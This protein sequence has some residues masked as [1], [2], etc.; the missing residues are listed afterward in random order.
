MD[1]DALPYI[2]RRVPHW[3]ETDGAQIVYTVCFVDYVMEAI[4][5]WWRSVIGLDWYILNTELSLGTPF[6]KLGMDIK[7][8]LTPKDELEMPVLIEKLGRSSLTFN[9]VGLRN[10]NEVSFE[11]RFVSSMV[12]KPA[13]RSIRIPQE[14]RSKIEAYMA[15]CA[16]VK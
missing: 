8:P 4:E 6:V 5:G 10:G 9:V 3:G 2:H 12:E 14:Y 11:A 13:L 15:A 16:T 1:A 7:C